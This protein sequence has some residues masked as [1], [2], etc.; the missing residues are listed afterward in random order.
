MNNDHNHKP[1]LCLP[2]DPSEPTHFMPG[3]HGWL[4]HVLGRP[5]KSRNPVTCQYS[6]ED[7]PVYLGSGGIVP[8]WRVTVRAPGFVY[9]FRGVQRMAGDMEACE[10]VCRDLLELLVGSGGAELVTPNHHTPRPV[11]N[12]GEA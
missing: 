3:Y 8:G 7:D 1:S 11:Y 9:I 4:M 5:N 2:E 12:P 10:R 6:R